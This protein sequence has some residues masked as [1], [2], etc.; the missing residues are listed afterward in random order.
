MKKEFKE[1]LIAVKHIWNVASEPSDYACFVL[2]ALVGLEVL[3][4]IVLIFIWFI[5]LIK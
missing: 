1:F 3:A 2:L 5:K 4:C